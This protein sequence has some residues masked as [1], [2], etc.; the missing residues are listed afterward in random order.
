M[1]HQ[2]NVSAW[3]DKFVPQYQW[4]PMQSVLRI[5]TEPDRNS[6]L[7]LKIY[8][9]SLNLTENCLIVN[10]RL[11]Y[12]DH[13]LPQSYTEIV[14]MIVAFIFLFVIMGVLLIIVTLLCSLCFC[15]L[16]ISIKYE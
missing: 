12:Q 3:N 16:D 1:G 14:A 6:L 5:D 2:I 11:N 10:R 4:Y 7:S 15:Y 13:E 8:Y 9:P